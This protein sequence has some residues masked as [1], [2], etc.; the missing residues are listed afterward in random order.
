MTLYETYGPS[1]L[2]LAA[3]DDS[4]R[5]QDDFYRFVNGRWLDNVSIP[6]DR[7]RYGTFDVLREEATRRVRSIIDDA[8]ELGSPVGTLQQKIGD[9][10][11]SF[12]DEEALEALGVTPIADD[13]ALA[14]SIVDVSSL[15]QVMGAL[16]ARGH[17]GFFSHFVAIDAKDSSSYIS[18]LGQ[19][20]LSLPNESYYRDE[21]YAEHRRVFRTHV[22]R[23]FTLA[24][25][26]NAEEHASNVLALETALAAHHW[27]VVKNREAELRYNKMTA[28]QVA[29]LLPNFDFLAWADASRTPR[30]ALDKVIV[31]QPSFFSGVAAVLDDF[32]AVAWRSWMA[33]QVLTGSAPYLSRSFVDENFDFFGRTLTGTPENRE[34]WKRGVALVEGALGEAIG[35]QY[36]ARHFPPEAKARMVALVSCVEEA[37]A[38]SIAELPWMTA[39]TKERA[40]A[41]LSAFRSKVAYPD[42]WRDY[43]A[44]TITRGDLLAN[45]AASTR[46]YRDLMFDRLGK[47]VDREEWP[48]TP[49]TVNACYVPVMN[50][51]VFPAGILQP[52]FFNLEA[53]DAVNFGGIAGVIG[54]EIGHGFDDQGSKYDGNGNL[55]NWWNDEDRAA[56]ESLTHELIAQFDQLSPSAAPDV[57][58]NGAFTIGENIGDLGGLG[59]ALKAYQIALDGREA[60]VLDGFTGVQRVLLGWASVWRSKARPEEARRLVAV[61]P[62]SPGELRASQMVRN[63][64][65]FYEAFNVVEGDAMYL[66]PERRVRIW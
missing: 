65:E 21:R 25:D 45:I 4:V 27:D 2:N 7:G 42:K 48:M 59:I 38:Q 1:G 29:A 30:H 49:Q 54:H 6:D 66:P 52:P 14:H 39:A 3:F 9:L 10:Y 41:K 36:V 53:D 13:L 47:P 31:Y 62:H 20:G 63:M 12:M 50:Q 8:A 64:P 56:F 58:V 5:P 57:C 22:A 51:I 19:A 18:A 24:G 34:R 28:A 46:F 16:K 15:A 43:S 32:D 55:E 60:P 17:S 61:D 23:M 40:Q 44:L 11:T 33:W 26:D 35:E 37:F